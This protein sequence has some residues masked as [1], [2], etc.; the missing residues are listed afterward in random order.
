M[1]IALLWGFVIACLD[2]PV[3]MSKELG[4]WKT[5]VSRNTGWFF[6]AAFVSKNPSFFPITGELGS[7]TDTDVRQERAL[8]NA[9]RQNSHEFFIGKCSYTSFFFKFLVFPD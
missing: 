7:R 3:E 4:S 8:K 6:V 2:D 9:N 1:A 5:W